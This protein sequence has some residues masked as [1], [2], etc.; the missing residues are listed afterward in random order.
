MATHDLAIVILAAGKGTRLKSNVAKVLHH[1]GG[2]RLIEHVLHAAAALKAK[3]TVAI[4]GHQ[5]DDVSPV[6]APLGATAVLQQPQNGTGHAMHVALVNKI[7]S[8][9]SLYE[10]V[11]VEQGIAQTA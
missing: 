9:K 10:T 3:R 11:T 5:A 6:V 7:M 2:R 1:A 4:V 8:D